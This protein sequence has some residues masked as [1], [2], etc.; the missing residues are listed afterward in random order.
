MAISKSY[1]TTI[2]VQH[3]W[4]SLLAA[5]SYLRIPVESIEQ[6]GIESLLTSSDEGEALMP[7]FQKFVELAYAQLLSGV[8]DQKALL[9]DLEQQVESCSVPNAELE[10]L[11]QDTERNRQMLAHLESQPN[12]LSVETHVPTIQAR[13]ESE[14]T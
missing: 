3:T 12:E 1:L 13:V 9:A 6:I 7:Q 14:T 2:G 4:P 5:L 8:D 11:E 10:K